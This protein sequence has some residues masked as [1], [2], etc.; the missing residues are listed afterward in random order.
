MQ[1]CLVDYALSCQSDATLHYLND[2]ESCCLSDH[3]LSLNEVVP[4][5]SACQV[6]PR[7]SAHQV[8]PCSVDERSTEFCG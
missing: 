1:L 6:V 7:Q 2:H 5:Q 3:A 4:C 8:I